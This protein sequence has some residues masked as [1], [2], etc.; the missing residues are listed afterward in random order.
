[1]ILNKHSVQNF[2]LVELLIAANSANT[3]YFF[4]EQNLLRG[5]IVDKIEFYP[6]DAANPAPSGNTAGL[7]VPTAYLTLVNDS[8]DEFV[9]NIP[10]AELTGVFHGF[11]RRVETYNAPFTIVPSKIIWPKSY[12]SYAEPSGVIT[13]YSV[14][15]GV[16]YKK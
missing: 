4:P 2:Q 11:I 12:I 14:L 7:T 8:G 10:V 13:N 16:Y 6:G 5:R 9:Q 3:K 15:F 1:M